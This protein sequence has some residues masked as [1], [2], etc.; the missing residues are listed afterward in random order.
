VDHDLGVRVSLARAL[1]S[2]NYRV[3]VAADGVEALGAMPE[4]DADLVLLDADLPDGRGWAAFQCIGALY[5]SVPVI[6]ITRRPHQ[7]ERARF[8]GAAGLL[9]KPLNVSVLLQRVQ[10]VLSAELV[11]NRGLLVT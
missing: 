2:E 7:E 9:E 6:L 5:P 11:G 8:A 10:E 1:E 3:T 4:A